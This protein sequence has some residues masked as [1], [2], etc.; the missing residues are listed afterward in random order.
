MTSQEFQSLITSFATIGASVAS[1]AAP[2]SAAETALAVIIREAP[3]LFGVAAI[4]L[5]GG[6]L[7][8]AQKK[9]AHDESV[10]LGDPGSIPPA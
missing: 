3:H 1:G 2:F 8:D 10:A 7:T 6:S 4:L 9:A 5:N